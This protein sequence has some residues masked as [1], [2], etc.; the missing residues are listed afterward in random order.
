MSQKGLIKLKRSIRLITSLKEA[1][2]F[3]RNKSLGPLAIE[4]MI[5]S[6]HQF[7]HSIL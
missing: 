6:L 7:F 5:S 4:I 1:C 2:P 3:I